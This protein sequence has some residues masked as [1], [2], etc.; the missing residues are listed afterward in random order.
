MKRKD[1]KIVYIHEYANGNVSSSLK[2]Y[3]TRKGKQKRRK[4]EKKLNLHH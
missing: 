4:K 1:L 2:L 3:I